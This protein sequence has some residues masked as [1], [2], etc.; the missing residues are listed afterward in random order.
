MHRSPEICDVAF[1]FRYS[2]LLPSSTWASDE[3]SDVCACAAGR[4][5]FPTAEA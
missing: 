2:L 4:W 5:E 1:F 3:L